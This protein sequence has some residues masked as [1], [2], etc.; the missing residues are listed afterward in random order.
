M[1][2]N[3]QLK[4]C[5]YCTYCKLFCNM[6][7]IQVLYKFL[8]YSSCVL[9]KKTGEH[10]A[11]QN[12]MSDRLSHEK[13][14]TGSRGRQPRQTAMACS[15]GMRQAAMACSSY[16]SSRGRQPWQAAT[17]ATTAGSYCRIL[18]ASMLDRWP[19]QQPRQG[20]IQHAGSFDS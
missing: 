17:A 5:M 13:K 19:G 14:M 20:P 1:E 18:H 15:Y 10:L 3:A 7:V 4:T 9:R 16:G 11:D 8:I 12:F 2:K 6:Y